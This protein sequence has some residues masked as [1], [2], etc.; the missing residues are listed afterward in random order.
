MV[1]RYA[2][3]E[4]AWMPGKWTISG[5]AMTALVGC[6][7]LETQVARSVPPSKPA[8]PSIE[9]LR[10][11]KPEKIRFSPPPLAEIEARAVVTPAAEPAPAPAPDAAPAAPLLGRSRA[12]M[13]A[14]GLPLGLKPPDLDPR[15]IDRDGRVTQR[16]YTLI[17]DELRR[18]GPRWLDGPKSKKLFGHMDVNSDGSLSSSDLLPILAEIER[19]K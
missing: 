13:A 9:K 7:S 14:V 12:V 4:E 11:W 1:Q 16:D 5:L 17:L 6:A 19:Q 2:V 10:Y 3:D 18:D 8:L 15:D